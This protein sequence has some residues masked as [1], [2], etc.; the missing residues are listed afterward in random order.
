MRKTLIYVVSLLVCLGLVGAVWAGKGGKKGGNTIPVTVEFRSL[1]VGGE[2]FDL[3]LG[4]GSID[5]ICSDGEGIYTDGEQNVQAVILGKDGPGNLLFST[6]K[7]A[8]KTLVRPLFFDL[9]P[10]CVNPDSDCSKLP[11]PFDVFPHTGLTSANMTM[12][13]EPLE[14]CPEPCK[15]FLTMGKGSPI[16]MQALFSIRGVMDD[17]VARLE[18][19][20][21]GGRYCAEPTANVSVMR[22]D[23][24]TGADG[25]IIKSWEII[26][27]LDSAA[28]CVSV[29]NDPIIPINTASMSFQA[30]VTEKEK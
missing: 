16:D 25:I 14:G 5:Q 19:N 9:G 1:G 15:G 3:V 17:N 28:L 22:L 2:C 29:R 27:D 8:K 18:F 24:S 13:I 26:A 20:A 23:D 6:P 4:L 10:F 11:S 12:S 30:T 7:P 21:T